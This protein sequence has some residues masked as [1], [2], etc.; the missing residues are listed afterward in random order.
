MLKSRDICHHSAAHASPIAQPTQAP[1]RSPRT[2]HSAAGLLRLFTN[3]YTSVTKTWYNYVNL[4]SKKY[5]LEVA[6]C[7]KFSI[8]QMVKC[9]K[10][11]IN[12]LTKCANMQK[13]VASSRR[14]SF[15]G[16]VCARIMSIFSFPTHTR[17]HF[18]RQITKDYKMFSMWLQNKDKTETQNALCNFSKSPHMCKLPIVW[19]GTLCGLCI[20]P[21]IWLAFLRLLV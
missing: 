9:A 3:C 13:R 11:L 15:G 6:F 16:R 17:A 8:N 21:Y 2:P 19:L 14:Q 1:Q 10:K 4:H 5:N 7:T 20:L 12:P 18:A